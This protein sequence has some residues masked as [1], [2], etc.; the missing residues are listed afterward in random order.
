MASTPL[1][2]ELRASYAANNHRGIIHVNNQYS[3]VDISFRRT[4]RVADG[5]D[6][7]RLPPDFGAFPL[8]AVSAFEKQLPQTMAEKGGVLFPM[9]RKPQFRVVRVELILIDI[10]DREG[11]HVD[12][13]RF[14]QPICH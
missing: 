11:S 6:T 1:Q 10:F 9:Y 2:C 13:F 12:L 4:I 3:T 7:S 14:A 5:Q 8:Y